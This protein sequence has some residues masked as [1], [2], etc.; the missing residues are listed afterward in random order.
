MKNKRVILWFRKD[1]RIHDNEAFTEAFKSNAEVYPVFVFDDQW[2]NGQ[3][4]FG[5]KRIGKFRTQFLLECVKDLK[6]NL[7]KIGLDLIVRKGDPAQEV[8]QLA[9][10]LKTYYVHCNRERT[11]DE[12]NNQER[13]EKK[14]WTI[15]QELRYYRGKM[16]LYTFDLPFPVTHVPSNFTGFKKEV[17]QIV[18][19]REP[20]E[21]PNSEDIIEWTATPDLGNMPSMKDLYGDQVENNL[22]SINGGEQAGLGKLEELT[23]DLLFKD[24]RMLNDEPHLSP[25]LSMGCLSPKM[26]FHHLRSHFNE[27]DRV[28]YK[29]LVID[30]LVLRDYLRLLGKKYGDE[31]FYKSGM[32]END[33]LLNLKDTSL[34]QNLQKANLEDDFANAIVY[35]L[36]TTGYIPG[37]A[38]YYFANYLIY[39]LQMDWRIGAE[40]FEEYLIDYDPCSNWVN[41]QLIAGQGPEGR[42]EQR[43][44][45]DYLRKKFDP[46]DHYI[47]KWSPNMINT[48]Q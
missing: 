35:Q 6:E 48:I 2:H 10:E 22:D 41:W 44:S 25:Y 36:L 40:F 19:I 47:E 34:I 21:E 11:R 24:S 26:V 27:K 37:F 3:S 33:E 39:T 18:P 5:F 23:Q 32:S 1:L 45:L 15:G 20:L 12:V 14:L 28:F 43:A 13:L 8:F 4:R 29:T 42:S 17:E 46:Q 38:R 7:R 30:D 9:K 16:L 31:I